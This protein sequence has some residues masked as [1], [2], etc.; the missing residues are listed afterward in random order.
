[1]LLQQKNERQ[2][3]KEK[4]EN[5]NNLDNYQIATRSSKIQSVRIVSIRTMLTYIKNKG[6]ANK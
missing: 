4:K 2:R 3:E 5:G 6:N 1:M